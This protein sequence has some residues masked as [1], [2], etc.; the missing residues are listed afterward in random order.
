MFGSC[1]CLLESHDIRVEKPLYSD[2]CALSH[3]ECDPGG[4]CW[5]SIYMFNVFIDVISNLRLLYDSQEG[6]WVEHSRIPLFHE[7]LRP[8][9]HQRIKLG[10]TSQPQ[11]DSWIHNMAGP[12]SPF[13]WSFFTH[14]Q[15]VYSCICH[16]ALLQPA[17]FPREKIENKHSCP[18]PRGRKY[19]SIARQAWSRCFSG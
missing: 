12:L 10:Y 4:L 13:S 8:F 14:W 17:K 15:V 7:N 2:I 11:A 5:S 1:L 9:T 3:C 16:P 18:A 19:S 6:L